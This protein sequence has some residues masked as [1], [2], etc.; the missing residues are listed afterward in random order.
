M[1]DLRVLPLP[2]ASREGGYPISSLTAANRDISLSLIHILLADTCAPWADR[3]ALVEKDA[4]A[5]AEDDVRA[6]L[7]GVATSPAERADK[8]GEL[9][10]KL[11]A[12]SG[13]P[14]VI[15]G[16]SIGEAGA[17]V[18]ASG[19]VDMPNKFVANLPYAVAATLVLDYFQ[20]FA[21][22]ESATVMVQKLSLI[23]I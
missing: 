6:A 11:G 10:C 4:L 12:P 17:S 22:L 8:A 1:D 20:R 16:G 7:A 9:V 14:D 5:L 21:W 19:L 3:F 13:K 23:H 2:I 18:N 15:V